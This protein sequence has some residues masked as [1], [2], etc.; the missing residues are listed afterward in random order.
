MA[1]SVGYVLAALGP[2][3]VGLVFDL[4]SA[5]TVPLALLLL[6]LVPQLVAG[7]LAGRRR[8]VDATAGE[9]AGD[10]EAATAGL[11]TGSTSR[12][13]AGTE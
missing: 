10:E 2:L 3:A 9:P 6:L 12:F 4:T 13:G 5:W 1:Q 11:S 8:W 7:A